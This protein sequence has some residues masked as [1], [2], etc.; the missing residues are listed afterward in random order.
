VRGDVT[1]AAVVVAGRV[2]GQIV[3]RQRAELL[4]SA[5]VNGS[6]HAPKVIIAEGAQ[7][8]GSVAMSAP[9]GVGEKAS[10]TTS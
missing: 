10:E 1:A 4:A 9:A 2:E 7:L 8:H 5:A 3:A 6:V